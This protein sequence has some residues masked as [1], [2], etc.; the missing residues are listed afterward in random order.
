MN[1][2]LIDYLK[3]LKSRSLVDQIRPELRNIQSIGLMDLIYLEHPD[4]QILFSQYSIG[5]LLPYLK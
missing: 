5:L 4:P 2:D 3:V 1:L